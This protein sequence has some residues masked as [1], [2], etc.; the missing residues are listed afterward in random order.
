MLMPGFR[1]GSAEV[2]AAAARVAEVLGLP[3]DWL[4]DAAKAFIPPNAVF[5]AWRSFS[6]LEEILD[7]RT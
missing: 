4:N 6:N 7:D 5:E 1:Q 2:R 3:D